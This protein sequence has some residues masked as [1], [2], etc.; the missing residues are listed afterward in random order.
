MPTATIRITPVTT[1]CQKLETPLIASPF[2]N[3]PMNNTPTA[4]PVTPPMPPRKLV[5]PSSTAA[6]ADSGISAPTSGLDAPSRPAWT[7][8]ASAAQAPTTPYTATSVAVVLMPDRRAA[9][10]F[11]PTA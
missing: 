5:P 11:P 4:G 1:C 9:S 10:M 7:T 6:A 3:V 2:C 8:P